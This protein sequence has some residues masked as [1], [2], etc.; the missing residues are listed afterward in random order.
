MEV[1]KRKGHRACSW[2][3]RT[4]PRGGSGCHAR[5]LDL[6]NDTNGHS[7]NW[8]WDTS[9]QGDDKAVMRAWAP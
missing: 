1:V 2:Q 5:S 3:A 6:I 7:S 4:M 9:D 8:S